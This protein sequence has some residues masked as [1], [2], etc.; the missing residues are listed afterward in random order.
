MGIMHRDI[1]PD[2]I[3]ISFNDNIGNSTVSIIDV[4][5]GKITSVE[6]RDDHTK[7]GTIYYQ[8]PEVTNGSYYNEKADIWS[9]GIMLYEMLNK[10]QKI[11]RHSTTVHV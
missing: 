1:K 5:M 7:C 4:G 8:A 6:A 2:N 9:V 3:M 11:Y 10:G